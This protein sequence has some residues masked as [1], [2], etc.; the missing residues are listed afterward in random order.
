MKYLYGIVHIGDQVER[1]IQTKGLDFI[2]NKYH[3][4][5]EIKG[6]H[7]YIT[8]MDVSMQDQIKIEV[9]YF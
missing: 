8:K 2:W 5:S 7:N 3:W 1:N 9:L 4:K 6:K